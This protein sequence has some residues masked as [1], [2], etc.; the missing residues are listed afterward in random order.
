MEEASSVAP[1]RQARRIPWLDTARG[2]GIILVVVAHAQRGLI[3]ADILTPAPSHF[4]ADATIYAFHMPLF[5]LLAGLHVGNGL[6]AGRT[7][8]FTDKLVTIVWPYALWSLLH[9]CTVMMVGSVNQPLGVADMLTLPW[10]P[11]A[12]FWFL[13][14]LFL[15]HLVALA[16]WPNRTSLIGLAMLFVLIQAFLGIGNVVLHAMQM[17]PFFAIGALGGSRLIKQVDD[18]PPLTAGIIMLVGWLCLAMSR[19][20]VDVAPNG[21]SD[22]III[23]YAGAAAGI[24]GVIGLS[25]LIGDRARWLQRMGQASMAIY[26]THTF[27]AAGLRIAARKSGLEIDPNVM[28]VASS[29][30]SLFA[31]LLVYEIAGRLNITTPLGLGRYVRR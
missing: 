1:Q 26:V 28:L 17:F 30:I 16:V 2:I 15:C 13:Y 14:A 18:I 23:F 8:Y 19:L 7:A 10:I 21:A 31:P 9:I 22:P 24:A 3:K 20:S 27:F 6:K 29:L 12:Q 5:F 11:V 4:A 25:V